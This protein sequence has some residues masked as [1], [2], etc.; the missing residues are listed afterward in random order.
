M[1]RDRWWPVLQ[2]YAARTK[3]EL[4]VCLTWM[5]QQLIN[6]WSTKSFV[7][8]S[9]SSPQQP[10]QLHLRTFILIRPRQA[11][12]GSF[13]MKSRVKVL[14]GC[15]TLACNL[16]ML[17]FKA[18]LISRQQRFCSVKLV[19]FPIALL[20]FYRSITRIKAFSVSLMKHLS[21]SAS[22]QRRVRPHRD[23]G[24]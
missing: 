4:H 1:F 16:R 13:S 7:T 5:H 9:I 15:C 10:R 3:S 11:P 21:Q 19:Q 24:I 2:S 14:I 20:F 12:L 17:S 6:T 8:P 18:D 22:R 23:A